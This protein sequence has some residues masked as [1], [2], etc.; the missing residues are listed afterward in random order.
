MENP[1]YTPATPA[2]RASGRGFNQRASD[3]ISGD[4][5]TFPFFALFTVF[6]LYPMIYTIYIS[7]FKWNMLG[8]QNVCRL[9]EL[10]Q[11]F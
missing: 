3:M 2:T 9:P 1:D 8:V 5:Y 6:G 7:L 11:F 4:L 10:P